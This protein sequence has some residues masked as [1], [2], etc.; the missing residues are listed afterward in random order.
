[1]LWHK[2]SGPLSLGLQRCLLHRYLPTLLKAGLCQVP[3]L[4]V[5]AEQHGYSVFHSCSTSKNSF[6]SIRS[7][8]HFYKQQSA[9]WLLLSMCCYLT[10]QAFP[11]A[12][13]RVRQ[14]GTTLCTE[15][16]LLFCF[17][18]FWQGGKFFKG[19]AC[20]QMQ[21]VTHFAAV[22]PSRA[23][24]KGSPVN[25]TLR[26]NKE[27]CAFLSEKEWLELKYFKVLCSSVEV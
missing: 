12:R 10:C 4:C 9:F 6:F 16:N 11:A 1:M 21:H 14:W 7:L 19:D 17:A 23:R 24:D 20:L 18:K 15:L 22:Y 27:I 25:V 2:A 13:R 3:G 8:F 26:I 5:R